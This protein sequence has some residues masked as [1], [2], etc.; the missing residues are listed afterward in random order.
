MCKKSVMFKLNHMIKEEA[1]IYSFRDP[2]ESTQKF[3]IAEFY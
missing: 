3:S 1:L 2:H